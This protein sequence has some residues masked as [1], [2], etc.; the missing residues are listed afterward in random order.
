MQ[1]FVTT[2][3][4]FPFHS[5][6]PEDRINDM[7]NINRIIILGALALVTACAVA[8]NEGLT[9]EQKAQMEAVIKKSF[10]KLNLTAEQKPRFEEITKKYGNQM[11]RLKESNKGRFAKLKMLRD[12][13]N[14]KNNEMR[15]LLS[16]GQYKVYESIQEE[17]R[18]K[19]KQKS[20]G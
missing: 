12:I 7:K 11:I 1:I 17:I 13:E 15:T 14:N 6:T 10:E 8:Q 16:T 18:Q 19:M 4:S 9:Y 5:M 2:L 20:L 3:S